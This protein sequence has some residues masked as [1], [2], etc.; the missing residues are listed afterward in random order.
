MDSYLDG[1]LY[2]NMCDLEQYLLDV[3]GK[4]PLNKIEATLISG[5][6]PHINYFYEFL[7][8]LGV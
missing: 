3:A 4:T 5:N 6:A 7:K 1:T 2:D 8:N